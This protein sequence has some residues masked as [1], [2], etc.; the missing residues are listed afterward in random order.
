MEQQIID[1]NNRISQ[2]ACAVAVKTKELD[3]IEKQYTDRINMLNDYLKQLHSKLGIDPSN[4]MMYDTDLVKKLK[5][6]SLLQNDC[7]VIPTK[8]LQ[9]HLIKKP[10]AVKNTPQIEP[11]KI[12]VQPKDK[13]HSKY[14]KFLCSYCNEKGHKRS[15]CPKILYQGS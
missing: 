4:E 10:N 12:F 11:K 3:S 2:L 5:E 6:E 8:L 15:Q 13:N 9:P 1:L 7:L 14:N